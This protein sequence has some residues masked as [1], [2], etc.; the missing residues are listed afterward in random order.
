MS[1]DP[2]PTTSDAA[3]EKP[4]D[5][6]SVHL[7]QIQSVRDGVLILLAIGLI[8][9]GN[10]LSIITVPL[11]VALLLAYLVE[12]VVAWLAR[13]VPRLGRKGAV[14]VMMGSLAL[15]GI[16]VL[17]GT[18]PVLVK[19]GVS[20]AHNS[21]RYVANLKEF[22]TSTDL[23]D[24]LRERLGKLAAYLPDGKPGP[25]EDERDPASPVTPS[26]PP[27]P[28]PTAQEATLQNPAAPSTSGAAPV[29]DEQRVRELIRAELAAQHPVGEGQSGVVGKVLSGAMQVAGFLGGLLGGLIHLV[30]F[31]FIS[32]FCFFFFST[33]FPAVRE[34]VRSFIPEN[35]RER[36]L[37]LIGKMDYA[38]SGFVRGR[39]LTCSVM[40][41]IYATGWTIMGVPHAVLLGLC[42]GVLGLIPYFSAIGLP[43]A[44]LLLA[45]SLTGTQDRTGWYFS[46]AAAGSTASIIWWKVL[47]FP[48]IVNF[49]AQATEDYVLNP[50][51]QGKATNLHPAVILLACIAGGALAGIYGMIL[52]IPVTACGKIMLDE[53]LMP[54]LKQWIDGR[55]QDPLPM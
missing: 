37:G 25:I 2:K 11:M 46:E 55:R 7:W 28:V 12:P 29:L 49:V 52:A 18:V 31:V 4:R 6:H 48:W 17:V 41:V 47:V 26:E 5:W 30:I 3:A 51:I 27:K 22:A 19:Q 1:D 43:M 40:A 54:R 35:N 39:L 20:L 50:M 33:S 23:P 44:W 8:Y 24:W 32:V 16:A 13:V 9:L 34:Y 45:M 21:D 15:G 53:V 36:T 10:V 42:V 14:L 38:I